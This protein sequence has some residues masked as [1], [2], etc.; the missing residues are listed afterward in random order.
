MS[1]D[2]ILDEYGFAP[3][4]AKCPRGHVSV[5]RHRPQD[6]QAG[7]ANGRLLF[8]CATCDHRWAPTEQDKREIL[9][10]L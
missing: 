2:L 5:Q 6:W 3:F 10:R 9:S 8:H 7:L 4:H 1:K